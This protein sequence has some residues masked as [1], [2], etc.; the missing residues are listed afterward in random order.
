[1]G[2]KIKLKEIIIEIE[3][4]LCI[5]FLVSSISREAMHYLDKYYI[6]LLFAM[7]HELS[8]ILIAS[9]LNRKLRKVFIS[10]CGMTAY[11]KYEYM[12]KNR[13][14]YIKDLLIFL[15]G[16]LSNLIIAYIFKDIKFIFEINVFLAILNLFPIYPLDGYNIV[17]S[18]LHVFF[19]GNKKKISKITSFISIFCLSILSMICILILYR[20]NN[21]SSIIFLIY[22]LVLNIRKY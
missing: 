5:A 1:M 17:K 9:I 10:I 22:I 12:N 7:Y 3:Y 19:I 15:A 11:F 16:P 14:Y 13:L 20:F 4:L 18:I 8:H 21:I 2:F 6:C